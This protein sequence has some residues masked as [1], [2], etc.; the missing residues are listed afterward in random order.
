MLAGLLKFGNM[1]FWRFL[2]Y[3]LC[4]FFQ[5]YSSVQVWAKEFRLIKGMT[6]KRK[7]RQVIECRDFQ[8]LEVLEEQRYLG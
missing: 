5:Y 7:G 3:L 4:N 2:F 8:V 6:D 1:N